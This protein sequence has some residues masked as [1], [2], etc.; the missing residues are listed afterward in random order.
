MDI[1][2]ATSCD[3]SCWRGSSSTLARHGDGDERGRLDRGNVDCRRGRGRALPSNTAPPTISGTVQQGQTL[4]AS[5]GTWTGTPTSFAYRGVTATSAVATVWTCRCDEPTY[6]LQASDVGAHLRVVVTA[7]NA[8]GST[9]ATSQQTAAVVGL[10]PSNTAL[11]SISGTPQQGQPV[12]ASNGTGRGARPRTPTAGAPATEAAA[13][14]WTSPAQPARRMWWRLDLAGT[15]R[16]VVTAT[17]AGGSTAATSA[18]TG[19]CGRCT[20]LER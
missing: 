17:N 20:A 10:P 2:G 19:S 16:V 18:Q 13:T 15:L 5:N 3:V 1:A 8:G 12:T 14:A 9:A 11:P 6:V 7:T 4:T